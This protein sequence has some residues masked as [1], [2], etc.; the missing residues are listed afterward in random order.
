MKTYKNIAFSLLL[1]LLSACTGNTPE[2]NSTSV[3]HMQTDKSSLFGQP[4][5]EPRVA[6]ASFNA[7][8]PYYSE[9]IALNL[10]FKPLDTAGRVISKGQF[11][12]QLKTGSYGPLLV[13]GDGKQPHYRL[14]PL[15]V[16]TDQ[17]I[18]S[19]MK[20]FGEEFFHFSRLENNPLPDFDFTT[21]TGQHYTAANTRGKIIL[22]KCWFISCKPCRE[23]MPELNRLVDLY[24]ERKDVIFLS[25]AIDGKKELQEF[26]K[27]TPFYYATVAYKGEYMSRKLF[28]TEYPT[29]FIVNRAGNVVHAL[30][31]VSE[32]KEAL[33]K[34]LA[35]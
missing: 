34:E 3:P 21:L 27:T 33:E 5:V 24:K 18:V 11:L 2:K 26:L 12:E 28:V 20:Q 9:Y 13:Y 1:L 14:Y 23:E 32:V 35:K 10:G 15:P 6:Y 30:K 16:G 8:W 17:T 7:F 19:Y 25:L 22:I 31:S 4:V 29:H